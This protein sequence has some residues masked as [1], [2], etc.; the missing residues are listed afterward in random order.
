MRVNGVARRA[1]CV[2]D[3]YPFFAQHLVD[4]RRLAD[5]RSTDHRYPNLILVASFVFDGREGI[6]H[7]VEQIAEIERIRRA[8]TY[9]LTQSEIIKLKYIV[10]KI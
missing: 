1:R 2:A 5:I 6:G 3:Y 7:G 8:Y 4:Q 10:L 9:R